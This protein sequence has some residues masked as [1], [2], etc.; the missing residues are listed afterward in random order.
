M[1][2]PDAARYPPSTTVSGVVKVDLAKVP[3]AKLK[4]VLPFDMITLLMK[5]LLVLSPLYDEP[6]R[7]E[8]PEERYADTVAV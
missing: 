4:F 6:N 5:V 1:S 8:P 7:Q 3:A 2:D